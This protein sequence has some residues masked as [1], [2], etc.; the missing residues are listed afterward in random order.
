[1]KNFPHQFND[2]EKLFNALSVAKQL[3]D[4]NTLLADEN[5]GKQLTRKGIYTY[6]DKN[7]SIDEYLK[8]HNNTRRFEGKYY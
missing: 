6:R 8:I 5:F 2:I 3:I 7:L 4:S 1:M